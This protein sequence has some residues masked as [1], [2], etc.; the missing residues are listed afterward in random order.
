[1]D[2]SLISAILFQYFGYMAFCFMDFLLIW[3]ILAGT[4]VVHIS[5]VG[6]SFKF[7]PVCKAEVPT[8]SD[9][10]VYRADGVDGP[11]EMERK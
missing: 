9:T 8:A 2:F 7:L 4:N 6:C 5:G 10:A 1:M 3:T 11:Q